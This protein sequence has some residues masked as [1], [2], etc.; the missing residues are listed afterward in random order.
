[1]T[2][3]E[4]LQLLTEAHARVNERPLA[5]V[6]DALVAVQ[7]CEFSLGPNPIK[8]KP[9]EDMYE[10]KIWLEENILNVFC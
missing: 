8:P 4:P 2:S 7:M 10:F 5:L 3:L 6:E 9:P 1:M